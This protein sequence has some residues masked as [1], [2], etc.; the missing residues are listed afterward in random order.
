MQQQFS[1][2]PCLFDSNVLNSG[3]STH[4]H[5]HCGFLTLTHSFFPPFV[6]YF[7]ASTTCTQSVRSSTLTSSRRISWWAWIR[8]MFG[9]SQLKPQNG[10]GPGHLPPL[11]QQVW[12]SNAHNCS[13]GQARFL[14]K[15]RLILFSVSTAP[16]PKQVWSGVSS[17]SNNA[18][19]T[20]VCRTKHIFFGGGVD[21]Q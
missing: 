19:I 7:R 8:L 13:Y 1:C 14:F 11:A 5:T 16:A 3:S 18:L 21:R 6:R 9:S 10:R 17:F 15:T 20:K 2:L 12:D 4:P